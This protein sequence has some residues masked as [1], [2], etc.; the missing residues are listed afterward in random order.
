VLGVPFNEPMKKRSAYQSILL[1]VGLTF[2][3]Q[4]M[5]NAQVTRIRGKVLD[6]QTS[7]P[8]PFVNI[9]IE[10][11]TL[12][13]ITDFNGDF[14]LETRLQPNSIV[15]SYIGYH[16]QRIPVTPGTFQEIEIRL[17]AENI[18]LDEIVVTPGENPAHRILRKIIDNK[19]QNDPAR[20]G[21]YQY[22][23]YNKMELDIN[24]L[25]E[26]YKN[27]RVFRQFQFIFD[28]IDTS[29]ITGKT[30]LPVFIVETLS[31]YYYQKDPPKKKEVIKAN[32]ISGIDSDKVSEFTGQMYLD[33]NIYDNF[34]PIMGLEMVS[35]IANFGLIYYKYYLIDSAF[36]D[37]H[38]CY[39]ISFR[40][41]RKMEPTFN[42]YF[43]V[44]DTTFA[45]QNYK[46]RLADDVNINFVD[47]FVA[48][49]TYTLVEDSV[50]FPM[51][52]ELFIDFAVTN[53]DYGFFGRKTTS[54]QNIKL[55]PRLNEKFF[56][57][58][59]AE[60]TIIKENA[61]DYNI[62]QWQKLRPEELSQREQDIYQMVDSIKEVP[63]FN[64]IIDV[65]NTVIT[66]YWVKGPIEIGPYYTLYSFNPIEGQR[67]KFGF[68]TSN[69]FSTKVMYNGH[70]AYGT[71][72]NKLKYG[73]GVLYDF[74]KNPRR[75]VGLQ[76][77]LDYEQLGVTENAFLSDNFLA[78]IFSREIN[79]KLTEVND[80]STYYEHEWFQGFSNTITLR[81][82]RIF[83]SVNVPF[84]HVNEL[85]DT[86]SFNSL[87]TSE[88]K[89][90]ARLAF[91][92]KFVYGEFERM[93]LGTRYPILNLNF[94]AGVQGIFES[95]YE[96]YKLNFSIEH[97]F[98]ISPFGDFKYVIDAG[99]IFGSAPYPFLQLHEGNQT[100]AYD[101]YAFNLMNYY[102]FVSNQYLSLMLE[103]HFN[104]F[105]LN[106][107]PLFRRLK[108]REVTGLK[109]LGGD[110]SERIP[111]SIMFP[112][113]LD[114]L[115]KPYMEASAGIENLFK[116]IRIDA[117]WRLTYKDKTDIKNFGIFGK[118]QIMF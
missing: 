78:S 85:N 81:N 47:D 34:V 115:S 80:I 40:P 35:P 90:N 20:I 12:G 93:S 24:N 14:F 64:S 55:Y 114:V 118:L 71:R 117:V 7:E 56:S 83:S 58:Q 73:A 76:Y 70:L 68:R 25:T 57:K 2:G 111:G 91:N 51:K 97:K 39:Q 77:K 23:I 42:G 4:A 21:S 116:F 88:I 86:L 107:V 38:W 110:L 72:D 5:L 37:N 100:Y 60:E 48:E 113:N 46:I 45:I 65:I 50:W 101:D 109:I 44:Q 43:W 31:D 19:K 41:K 13:T 87:V 52:Q 36:R 8:L 61:L 17:E 6:Q 69:S 54:F 30:F 33:F 112:E 22:E 59:L 95:D 66:G 96:Y 63:L 11:T 103:H 67:F 53:K 9:S 15:A 1:I 104:G 74:N 108:L 27:Q 94:T 28:Y 92:E 89:L 105:F 10:G 3:L 29:A 49:Q 79:D 32:N 75:R 82:K 62:E 16:M 18:E 84:M 99:K 26:E 102:E 106:R 98:P